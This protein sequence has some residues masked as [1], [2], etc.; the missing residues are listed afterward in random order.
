MRLPSRCSLIST[1]LSISQVYRLCTTCYLASGKDGYSIFSSCPVIVRSAQFPLQS[2]S[3][4]VFKQFSARFTSSIVLQNSIFNRE[5]IFTCLCALWQSEKENMPSLNLCVLNYLY[6]LSIL[7]GDSKTRPPPSPCRSRSRPS[8]PK[9]SFFP[10]LL[11]LLTSS[12][13]T[14]NS[15]NLQVTNI[16]HCSHLAVPLLFYLLTRIHGF[17][18]RILIDIRAILICISTVNT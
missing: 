13:D 4:A 8:S 7:R 1:V 16:A 11:T 10:K 6:A 3:K 15:I 14:S 5:I 17:I 12:S 9:P 18:F 2:N